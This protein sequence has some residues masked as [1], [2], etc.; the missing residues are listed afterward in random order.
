MIFSDV[1]ST[2]G[3]VALVLGITLVVLVFRHS[4]YKAEVSE[5]ATIMRMMLGTEL[6][7]VGI[8]LS[9]LGFISLVTHTLR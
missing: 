1:I 5:G 6:T 8:L 3:L 4:K 9:L 7:A 2:L